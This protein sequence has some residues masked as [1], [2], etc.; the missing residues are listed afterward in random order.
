MLSYEEF[1]SAVSAEK[2]LL[3]FEEFKN[4][5]LGVFNASEKECDFYDFSRS[6]VAEIS[7]TNCQWLQ[8]VIKYITD[9][10]N[11]YYGHWITVKTYDKA[12]KCITESLP[13]AVEVLAQ[14]TEESIKEEICTFKQLKKLK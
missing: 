10:E 4:Q 5:V 13:Q 6:F 9:P 12:C 1:R 14:R 7:Y 2:Q 11:C 8:F 3:S